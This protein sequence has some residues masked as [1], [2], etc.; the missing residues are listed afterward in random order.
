MDI[1]GYQRIYSRDNRDG[2]TD[3]K[4]ASK[5]I[6]TGCTDRIVVFQDT[7]ELTERRFLMHESLYKGHLAWL[8]LTYTFC[9]SMCIH[10]FL[11]VYILHCICL[12]IYFVGI[13]I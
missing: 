2:F 13:Q 9:N 1:H 3:E 4:D 11:E 7:R 6:R 12:K 5:I 10:Q 8:L